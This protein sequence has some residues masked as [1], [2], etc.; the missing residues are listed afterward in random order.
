MTITVPVWMATRARIVPKVWNIIFL[1]GY[2]TVESKVTYVW[3]SDP[4]VSLYWRNFKFLILLL[5]IH[6][7]IYNDVRMCLLFSRKRDLHFA[8]ITSV[9][10]ETLAMFNIYLYFQIS[11]IVTMYVPVWLLLKKKRNDSKTKLEA[12]FFSHTKTWFRI[13]T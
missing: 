7:M 4:S 3:F 2:I 13:Y 6:T 9:S 5:T 11:I 10:C 12:H 1:L 8:W